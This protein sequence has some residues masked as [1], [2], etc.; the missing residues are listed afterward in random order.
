[1]A[2]NDKILYTDFNTLRNAVATILGT[3]SGTSG[4]GQTVQSSAVSGATG[5]GTVFG[6]GTGAS[7]I[8]TTEYSQ[9]RYDIINVYRHIY[10]ADPTPANPII[11]Q[12]VR[13]VTASAA[14]ASEYDISEYNIA[15]YNATSIGGSDDPYTQFSVFISDIQANR[16]TCATS[17]SVVESKASVV[18]STAWGGG[19]N[20]I[21]SRISVS[22]LSSNAARFFFNSGG[23]IRI[24]STR[25][26]GSA[27]SQNTAWTNLLNGAGTRTFSAQ[28]PSATLGL[29]NATNWYNLTNVYQTWYTVTDSSPYGANNYRIQARTLNGSVAN[30]NTGTSLGVDF[31]V[32]F[33]DNYIDPDTLYAPGS[34]VNVPPGDS[35]DG[36]LTISVT[37][38]RASGVMAPEPSTG[39]FSVASPT[40]DVFG[41]STSTVNAID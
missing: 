5:T 24:A 25:T 30:N 15:E 13:W 32:L 40:V 39:A 10:G 9:L 8:T 20:T 31:L 21:G 22:F 12:L 35:V 19:I 16:F 4:Y 41:Q 26:G 14:V 27:T 34:A 18:R 36:T 23:E 6:G 3:G 28:Q 17:Q 7:K 29:S 33:Q 2:V 11:G 38:K 1:M 37:A